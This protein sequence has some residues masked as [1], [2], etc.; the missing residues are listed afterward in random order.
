MWNSATVVARTV[1][2]LGGRQDATAE[3]QRA[4]S[5]RVGAAGIRSRVAAATAGTR[6]RVA[7]VTAAMLGGRQLLMALAL[8]RLV[9]RSRN[10][11]LGCSRDA[12]M[13]AKGR[14]APYVRI[15]RVPGAPDALEAHAPHPGG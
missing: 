4:R 3:P 8:G 14:C 6:V 2:Q 11:V 12:V 15:T 9:I 1:D 5:S 13:G 7:A 10:V